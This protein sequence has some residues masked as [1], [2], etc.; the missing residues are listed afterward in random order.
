MAKVRTGERNV[1][2]YRQIVMVSSLHSHCFNVSSLVLLLALSGVKLIPSV[3]SFN[4]DT[5]APIVKFGTPDSYFGYSVAIHLRPDPET[6]ATQ[7]MYVHYLLSVHT[8]FIGCW[9]S[10]YIYWL[11][12]D[13]AQCGGINCLKIM[14]YT[15]TILFIIISTNIYIS[16]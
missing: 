10:R 11:G 13:R 1:R 14:V 2:A 15:L 3:H 16:P 5:K 8:E 4:I 7:P 9:V 6:G 12:G